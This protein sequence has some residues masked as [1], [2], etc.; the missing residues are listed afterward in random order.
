MMWP[1]SE[2]SYAGR[3]C[4]YHVPFDEKTSLLEK[5]TT[6]QSWLADRRNP[7]NLIMIYSNE[8]EKISNIYGSHSAEVIYTS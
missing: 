1:G 7:P 5:F 8:L 3:S 6:V 4:T 2:F